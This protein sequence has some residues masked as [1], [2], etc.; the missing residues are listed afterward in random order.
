MYWL[1]VLGGL[2]KLFAWQPWVVIGAFLG[3]RTV[4][5]RAAQYCEHHIALRLLRR[6]AHLADLVWESLLEGALM[7]TVVLSLF[8]V[9]VGALDARWI[10]AARESLLPAM[11]HG[12]LDSLVIS[13]VFLMVSRVRQVKSFLA[14]V[15][16]FKIFVEGTLLFDFCRLEFT[17]YLSV[18]SAIPAGGTGLAIAG[19]PIRTQLHYAVGYFIIG[20]LIEWMLLA[21][22]KRLRPWLLGHGVQPDHARRLTWWLTLANGVVAGFLP[23]AMYAELLEL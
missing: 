13:F 9:F 4:L 16:S 12:A 14:A 6:G 17:K 7:G 2:Q 20:L 8:L 11:E 23:L 1:S 15:P 10:S 3:L 18:S 5:T 21:A 22:E 19:R